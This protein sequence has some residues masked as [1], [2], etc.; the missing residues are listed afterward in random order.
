MDNKRRKYAHHDGPFGTDRRM[1]VESHPDFYPNKQSNQEFD[2][3]S[4]GV[5]SIGERYDFQNGR[6]HQNRHG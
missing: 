2:N 4:V 6:D 1:Y 5:D 3:P